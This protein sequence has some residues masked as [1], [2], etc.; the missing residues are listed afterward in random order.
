MPNKKAKGSGGGRP[1]HLQPVPDPVEIEVMAD[2]DPV[3]L[4]EPV[5]AALARDIGT[6]RDPLTVECGVAEWLAMST[7]MITA[8]VPADEAD[9]ALAAFLG[10]FVEVARRHATPQSLAV[11][12]A[13]SALPGTPSAEVAG[14]AA[15]ELAASGIADRAWVAKL[16]Q[17]RPTSCLR[18]GH[19]D[20]SQESLLA[21]FGYGRNEHAIAVLI[22]HDLGGG[23][24]DCWVTV[25]PETARQQILTTVGFDPLVEVGPINWI[26]AERILRTALSRPICAVDDDQVSDTAA[27]VPLLRRRVDVLGGESWQPAAP[28]AAT[29]RSPAKKTSTSRPGSRAPDQLTSY[30]LKVTLTGSKPPIWRRFV[31]PE[32]ISLDRL[33]EVIQ[34]GFGWTDS[35]LH[36]FEIDGENFGPA[37]EWDEVR[38][39]RVSLRRLVT[40]GDRFSYVYDFGDDWRH[41]IQVEKRLPA[42]PGPGGSR[43][44]AGRRAAPPEDCG[45]SYGYDEVLGV[46]SDPERATDELRRWASETLGLAPAGLPA[47]D[48]ARFDRDEIDAA[49]SV[50]GH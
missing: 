1:Q 11:L 49:L 33:H 14:A 22:D 2:L 47:Y 19:V 20:G 32:S 30:Q 50:L 12:R 3:E 42:G 16:S 31:V 5:Y 15:A 4:I 39:E 25:E 6:S 18:Y 46:I 26:R 40:V 43:C 41:T 13:L 24:K 9:Q 34:V 27:T 38:S 35:H 36:L 17:V 44:L 28:T 23:I 7:Q 29:R 8:G 10:A 45:G 37:G 48:P 21:G